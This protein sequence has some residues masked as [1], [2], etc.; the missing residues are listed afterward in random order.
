MMRKL[1]STTIEGHLVE[2]LHTGEIDVTR[3]VN[4]SKIKHIKE[5]IAKAGTDKLTPIK[6]LLG[7]RYSYNEIK[8]VIASVTEPKAK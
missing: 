2:Y 6:E 4:E 3:L 8:F 7:D 5:A 1:T